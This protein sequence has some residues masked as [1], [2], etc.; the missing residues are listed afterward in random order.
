MLVKNCPKCD[1]GP[2]EVGELQGSDIAYRFQYCDDCDWQ[3]EIIR[4]QLVRHAWGRAYKIDPT[5]VAPDAALFET[6]R[7]RLNLTAETRKVA[8]DSASVSQHR[9]SSPCPQCGTSM[10]LRYELN[11]DLSGYSSSWSC[12]CGFNS[13]PVKHPAPGLFTH[14]ADY[15]QI[16]WRGRNYELTENEKVYVRQLH[17]A[18][19]GG[20]PDVH[21][22]DLLKE[23]G[24]LTGRKV[25]DSFR[26]SNRELWGTLIISGAR[27]GTL[28]LNL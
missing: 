9:P 17:V 18:L 8:L 23:T 16:S 12:L 21:Q 20:V 4:F 25:R 26:S 24:P 7:G 22:D 15:R 3:G 6:L 14:T 2:L 11:G 13:P 27:R 10:K 1:L 28:R 19:L 5:T